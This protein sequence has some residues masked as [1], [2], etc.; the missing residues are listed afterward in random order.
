MT[1][2]A[3][4]GAFASTLAAFKPLAGEPSWL[5][6]ERSAAFAQFAVAG[7]PQRT[8]EEWKY[9]STRPLAEGAFAIPQGAATLAAARLIPHIHADDVTLVFVDGRYSPVHSAADDIAAGVTVLPLSEAL[10]QHPDAL[11]PF[12][13]H[14]AAESRPFALLNKSFT[15]DGVYIAVEK[16]QAAPRTIHVLYVES[17]AAAAASAVF[18]LNIIALGANAQASVVESYLSAPAEAGPAFVNPQTLIH[19]AD[20]ARLNHLRMTANG[21]TSLHTGV[22]TARLAKDAR[23]DSFV[24]TAGGRLTRHDLRADLQG[25]GAHATLDGLT[26][27]QAKEHTDHHTIVDHQVPDA[28]SAQLYKAIL[29]GESRSVFN[30]K[31]F[32][33]PDAQRTDARQQSRSLLLSSDAEADTKPELQIDADDVK[34]SHGAAVGPL[35]PDEVFY[36]ESRGIPRQT[37]LNMLS[38]AFAEDVLLRVTNPAQHQRLHALT[39]EFFAR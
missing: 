29:G 38:F 24:F 9:T 37:A 39:K 21:P 11:K 17:G 2:S 7:L 8:N 14:E 32:V 26:L 25:P 1:A 34:C 36:L 18:P 15:N 6:A 13:E 28:T 33:R 31:I 22:T 3:N 35:N 20:G 19:L 27:V 16:G 10:R 5:A 30:G 23:L 12:V 4:I